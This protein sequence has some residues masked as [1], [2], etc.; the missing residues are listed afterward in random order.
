MPSTLTRMKLATL[1]ALSSTPLLTAC[2]G[3]RPR[4][5][6]PPVEWAQPVPQ[7]VIPEGEATCPDGGR[8]LSD[9][10]TGSLLSDFAAALDNANRRLLKL[11]DWIITAQD[12][13]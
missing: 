13:H 8:C 10:Q 11:R 6:T 3:D 1:L 9:A 12:S 7:P 2:G 5:A 4:L